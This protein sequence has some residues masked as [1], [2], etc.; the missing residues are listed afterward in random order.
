[1][2]IAVN[3]AVIVAAQRP[4]TRLLEPFPEVV[5]LRVAVGRRPGNAAQRKLIFGSPW[6]G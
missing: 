6:S 2:L 5:G 3:V 1:V 4:I